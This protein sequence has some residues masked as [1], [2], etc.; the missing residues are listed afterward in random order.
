MNLTRSLRILMPPEVWVLEA[1]HHLRQ[2]EALPIA[3]PL[4][5]PKK[6]WKNTIVATQTAPTP[7]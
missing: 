2:E 5:K 6:P 7:T 1:L 4:A 3:H